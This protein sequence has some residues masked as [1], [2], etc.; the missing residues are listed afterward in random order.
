MLRFGAF[1]E[2]FKVRLQKHF[3]NLRADSNVYSKTEVRSIAN[4]K[5]CSRAHIRSIFFFVG[6]CR[7][8][9]AQGRASGAC[10]FL[11]DLRRSPVF[12]RQAP[13]SDAVP[14]RYNSSMKTVM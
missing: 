7:C 12:P 8:V 5:N 1:E 14:E 13:S 2:N 9:A 3:G 10:E 6:E 11:A 4:K